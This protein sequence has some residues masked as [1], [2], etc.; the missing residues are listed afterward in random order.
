LWDALRAA[1]EAHSFAADCITVSDYVSNSLVKSAVE[2]QLTIIGEALRRIRSESP[3]IL[4]LIKG[5][6][7]II[8]LRNVLTH[9]YDKMDYEA[10]WRI[11]KVRL[12][13]LISQLNALLNDN[14]NSS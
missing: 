5:S 13:D 6:E 2:R 3:D 8:G 12:P 11:V 7:Q 1:E 14:G 9:D 10:L 4:S